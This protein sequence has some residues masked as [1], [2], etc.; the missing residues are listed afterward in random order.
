[1]MKFFKTIVI[2][3]ALS[4]LF[5]ASYALVTLPSIFGDNMVFQ[6]NSTVKIWGWAKPY[7]EIKVNVGWDTTT[8]KVLTKNQM[9]WQVEIPTPAGSFTPYEITVEGWRKI[10][11]KNILIGEVWLC[12]GQSNMEWS[13]RLGIVNKEAEIA[14][15]Y[16]PYI[17]FF[18]AVARKSVE[19]QDDLYGEWTVC[20]PETMIDFSAIGYFFARDL[21]KKLHVPIGIINSSVGGSPIETWVPAETINSNPILKAAAERLP[22]TEWA[23]HQPGYLYNAMIAPI[24]NF[25]IKGVLWYQGEANEFNADMY[26][27]LFVNLITTWRALWGENLPFYYAQIAPFAYGTPNVCPVIQNNQRKVLNMVD[28]VEMIVTNAYVDD[29]NNI[30]P[31]QKQSVANVFANVALCNLYNSSPTKGQRYAGPLYDHYKV[32]GKTMY[33]YFQNSAGLRYYDG[34]GGKIIP[35]FEIA[36]AD[37]KYY[38]AQAKIGG[39]DT[40]Q[41]FIVLTSPKVSKPVSARYAWSNTAQ[42]YLI[43]SNGLSTSCFTTEE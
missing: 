41:K 33:V 26:D 24:T 9:V 7:E 31:I 35:L 11:L 34:K 42:S 20:S 25:K 1:M 17:R 29:V 36:G 21:Q 23:P 14:T 13:P 18:Q 12:S 4:S 10:V 40:A 30:H 6:Q 28:N 19:K 27:T 16:Y 5:T 43:N 22:E 39:N 15:A 2:T 32:E 8:Y 37:G 38:P 3:I